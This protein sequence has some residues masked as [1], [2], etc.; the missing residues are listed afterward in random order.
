[1]KML[2]RDIKLANYVL[3]K[4]GKLILIDFGSCYP[5]IDNTIEH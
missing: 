2:H 4:S 1:M 3:D 5:N